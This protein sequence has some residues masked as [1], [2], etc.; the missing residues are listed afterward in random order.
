MWDIGLGT[1][2]IHGQMC[3]IFGEINNAQKLHTFA[4]SIYINIYLWDIFIT[5]S[6]SNFNPERY[7]RS[8]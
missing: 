2:F 6:G 3:E 8:I 4:I 7:E 5:L 1:G